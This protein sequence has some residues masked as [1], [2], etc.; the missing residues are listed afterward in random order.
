MEGPKRD[1]KNSQGENEKKMSAKRAK[2]WYF[3]AEMVKFGLTLTH[4]K[5]FWIWANWG[6]EN[7]IWEGMP[8]VAPP[9]FGYKIFTI[10]LTIRSYAYLHFV[11]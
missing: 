2:I 10:F 5:L 3:Y 6:Q 8:P 9:L 4:L 11:H 1:K 7:I